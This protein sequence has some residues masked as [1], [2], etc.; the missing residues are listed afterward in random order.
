[1]TV[2]NRLKEQ[3]LPNWKEFK[4]PEDLPDTPLPKG[5]TPTFINSFMFNEN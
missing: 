4:S 3:S 1:M 2:D 5:M